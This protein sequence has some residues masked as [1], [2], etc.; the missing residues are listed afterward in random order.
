MTT[1]GVVTGAGRGMGRACADRVAEVVDVVLLV[2]LDEETATVAAK[3]IARKGRIVEP[4]VLDVTADD[5]LARLAARVSEAGTLRALVHAAGISP[6]MGDWRRVLEVD[7]VGTAK[8]LDALRPQ[9]TAGTAVVCFASMAT[10]MGAA[11]DDARADAAL[12][13]PLDEG[14]L[15][16]LHDALGPT[17]EDSGVAY[18]WAKRGVQRLVQRE[19]VRWG[20]AGGRVNGLSPGIIDTPM[21]QLEFDAH[22]MKHRLVAAGPFG[23]VG[24]SD[25]IAAAVAFLLSEEASWVSGIDLLVD[26]AICATVRSAAMGTP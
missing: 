20:A 18:T 26:G 10:Y 14:F 12:D 9:A 21:G 15:D 7:L 1:V 3:E 19:A 17:I 4:F 5:G 13:R 25:E 11:G 22:P 2:D 8:L 23:R 16:R 24:R 6:S